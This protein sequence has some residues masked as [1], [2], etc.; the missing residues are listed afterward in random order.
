MPIPLASRLEHR[1]LPPH[2]TTIIGINCSSGQGGRGNNN[3][4]KANLVD[5][6]VTLVCFLPHGSLLAAGLLDTVVR[7]WDRL[8]GLLLNKLQRHKDSVY[9]VALSPNNHLLSQQPQ[10][11]QNANTTSS[12]SGAG[13]ANIAALPLTAST[14]T[15]MGHKHYV[16]SVAVSRDS[17]WI[18]C[19]ICGVQFWDLKKRHGPVHV[20]GPRELGLTCGPSRYLL[21][22]KVNLLAK[23]PAQQAGLPAGQA[24]TCCSASRLTC[25]SNRYL[26]GKQVN[27]LAKQAPASQAGTGSASSLI[28]A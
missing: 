7:L 1:A 13:G 16:L 22:K 25:W 12:M 24:G 17:K 14:T 15:L 11:Q 21:G 6:G 20:A 10:Q 3:N 5:A 9:L 8:K 27:L 26:L 18:S 28:L 23:L 4:N 2:I 19:K